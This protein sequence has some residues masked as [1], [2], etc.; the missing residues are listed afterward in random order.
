MFK[1]HWNFPFQCLLQQR[2]AQDNGSKIYKHVPT[3]QFQQ[4]VYYKLYWDIKM[5]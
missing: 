2:K 3:V 5:T 4:F 1:L